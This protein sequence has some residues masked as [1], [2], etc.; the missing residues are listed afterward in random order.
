MKTHENPLRGVWHESN[1]YANK[2]A[3]HRARCDGQGRILPLGREALSC[4][5]SVSEMEKPR[6]TD[7]GDLQSGL[8]EIPICLLSQGF[9]SELTV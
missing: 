6:L 9:R 1:A 7:V 4:V 3:E 8:G 2:D 5:V